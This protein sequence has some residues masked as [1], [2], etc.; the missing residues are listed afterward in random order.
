MRA[1]VGIT[2][3]T[4]KTDESHPADDDEAIEES[5]EEVDDEDDQQLAEMGNEKAAPSEDEK[6]G[7]LHNVSQK[8]TP[9]STTSSR[10]RRARTLSNNMDA[11]SKT[12]KIIRTIPLDPEPISIGASKRSSIFKVVNSS[13]DSSPIMKS[14]VSTPN[15]NRINDRQT[16]AQTYNPSH[17]ANNICNSCHIFYQNK[18]SN[19][20]NINIIN[21]YNNHN[22]YNSTNTSKYCNWIIVVISQHRTSAKHLCCNSL[23]S[24]SMNRLYSLV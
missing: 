20:R 16:R 4:T 18:Q 8:S 23:P 12:R 7:S 15:S 24:R 11:E 17:G 14:D 10:V 1:Q 6:N 19:R 13:T 3:L 22:N 21:N 2:K 9:N 5:Q